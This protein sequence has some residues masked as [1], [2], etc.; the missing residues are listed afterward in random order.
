MPNLPIFDGTV[1]HGERGDGCLVPTPGDRT[2]L[3]LPMFEGAQLL[4]D[5]EIDERSRAIKDIVLHR[6]NSTPWIFQGNQG[7]CL[8][9]ACGHVVMG[10]N[11]EEGEKV[12]L[13]SQATLYRWD[14]FDRDGFLIPRRADNGMA[15]ATGLLLLRKIGIAPVSVIDPK[16][17]QGR[18]WPAGWK[19]KAD[20]NVVLEWRNVSASMRAID[21]ALARGS[22]VLHGWQGHARALV[23]RD[24]DTGNYHA[25]NTWKSQ[26]WHLLTRRQVDEGRPRYE[27]FTA[28]STVAR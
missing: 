25:K 10:L 22:W 17:W 28:I 14:G 4:S 21:S 11:A 15:L 1:P 9:S 19:T 13:L 23:W 27:A 26:P 18:N 3:G 2:K 20:D 6:A 16:D 5:G 12:D 24:P 7:S 8:P